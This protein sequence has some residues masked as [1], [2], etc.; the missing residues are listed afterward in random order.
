MKIVEVPNV[1]GGSTELATILID[2]NLELLEEN[3][4]GCC[5][6]LIG[7]VLRVSSA[8]IAFLTE[9]VKVFQGELED[10]QEH[11]RC[12]QV[13]TTSRE[14][15]SPTCSRRTQPQTGCIHAF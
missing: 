1:I 8:P 12:L 5:H 10:F 9:T 2:L 3:Y 13:F 6:P 11:A 7:E 4:S 14:I 15:P